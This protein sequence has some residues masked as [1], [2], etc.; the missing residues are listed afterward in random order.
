[1]GAPARCHD[2]PWEA[3]RRRGPGTGGKNIV[4][5]GPFGVFGE[6]LAEFA[7][8]V[9]DLRV[10][11]IEE[12]FREPLTV[13]VRGRRGVGRGAVTAALAD[14]GVTVTA[15]ADAD[16]D[17][18][19][20]GADVNVFVVAEVLKPEDR[21]QLRAACRVPAV[22]GTPGAA[23]VV[24]NKAD[25][26]GADPGGPLACAERRAAEFAATVG[27]PVVPMIAPLATVGFDDGEIAALRALIGTPVDMTSTDAF[28]G[29]AHRLPAEL[30]RRLLDKLDRFGLAHAVLAL[31]GG[32][33]RATVQRRLREVS[34][35]DRVLDQLIA[36]SA[37]ARYRKVC[38]VLSELRSLAAQRGGAGIEEFLVADETVIAVMAAA[39]DVVEAAGVAVERGDARD[40]HLRRA[41][42][43]ETYARGPVGVLHQQCAKDISRGSLRLLGRVR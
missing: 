21:A 3:G 39:V 15:D 28:V 9:R 13:V 5:D 30:R 29:S 27:V 11:E 10:L 36:V 34:Q 22:A 2:S 4:I 43:W 25:L 35:V 7:A 1:M 16:A 17:A 18:D 31:C 37:P 6:L 8:R 23:M 14:S 41:A 42:R 33:T 19:S 26:T 20:E 12:R 40:A 38:A 24:L 32:A